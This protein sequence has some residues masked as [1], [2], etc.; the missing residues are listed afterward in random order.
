MSQRQ[1]LS[2]RHSLSRTE[3][4]YLPGDVATVFDG[5]IRTLSIRTYDTSVDARLPVQCMKAGCGVGTSLYAS[6]CVSARWETKQLLG[7]RPQ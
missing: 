3:D 7:R 2:F 5:D 6:V 1:P 4:R